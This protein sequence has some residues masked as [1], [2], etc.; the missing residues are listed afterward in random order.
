MC[1]HVSAKVYF[2]ISK[3]EKKKQTSLCCMDSDGD[4]DGFND[5]DKINN[6]PLVKNNEGRE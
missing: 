2:Y 6:S 4:L 3:S 5:S 1:G